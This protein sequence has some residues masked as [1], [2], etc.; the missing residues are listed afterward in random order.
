MGEVLELHLHGVVDDDLVHL[1]IHPAHGG[2]GAVIDLGRR[3]V[4][5]LGLAID[6]RRLEVDGKGHRL[7]QAVV[8]PGGSD[9][10]KVIPREKI[11][12][13]DALG[14]PDALPG[15][16]QHRV[17]IQRLRRAEEDTLVGHVHRG[18]QAAGFHKSAFL[19]PF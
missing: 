7:P 19:D 6:P 9:A 13:D 17:H 10:E 5:R 3:A 18:H 14:P 4:F 2:E 11:L 8:P 16:F 15:A 12:R 1:V